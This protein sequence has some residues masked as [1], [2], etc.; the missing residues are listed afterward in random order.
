MPNLETILLTGWVVKNAITKS[1]TLYYFR[2]SL[3]RKYG[4]SKE[5]ILG[6]FYRDR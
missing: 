1:L 2:E 5:K 6:Y 3:K 4:E